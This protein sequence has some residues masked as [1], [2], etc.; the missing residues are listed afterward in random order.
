MLR[1]GRKVGVEKGALRNRITGGAT[2]RGRKRA[3]QGA[4]EGA[5]GAAVEHRRPQQQAGLLPGWRETVGG[6][7]DG[8]GGVVEVEVAPPAGGTGGIA[9]GG[10]IGAREIRQGI[11]QA[12]AFGC[13]RQG[14][15]IEQQV[16]PWGETLPPAGNRLGMG[17]QAGRGDLLPRQAQASG[18]AMADQ[19]NHAGAGVG[20]QGRPHLADR[21][22]IG[23]ED[24]NPGPGQFLLGH[25]GRQLRAE[26]HEVEG[27]A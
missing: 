24:H 17:L 2:G 27:S 12:P 15:A 10:H 11:H 8:A 13:G 18:L 7:L 5:G 25:G 21:I 23:I 16:G 19:A 20:L 4:G 3:G 6:G 22:L 1:Q 14:A 26:D 9:V